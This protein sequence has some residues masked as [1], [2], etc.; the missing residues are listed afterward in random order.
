MKTIICILIILLIVVTLIYLKPIVIDDSKKESMALFKPFNNNAIPAWGLDNTS[1]DISD[2]L[3]KLEFHSANERERAMYD[4]NKDDSDVFKLHPSKHY[5]PIVP[6]QPNFNSDENHYLEHSN[7][8]KKQE[9]NIPKEQPVEPEHRHFPIF[10]SF[11]E[12][13]RPKHREHRHRRHHHDRHE[14][15]HHYRHH[16]HR[17]YHSKEKNSK[18][19]F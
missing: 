8:H 19:L 12:F 13:L 17:H 6:V 4:I 2:F 15:H 9:N 1:Y 5:I 11:F 16:N 14:R 10:S 3:K 7:Q 18:T